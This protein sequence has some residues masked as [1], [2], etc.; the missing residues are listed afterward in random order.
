MDI[1]FCWNSYNWF[2]VCSIDT[3]R[4]CG[5]CGLPFMCHGMTQLSVIQEHV[6]R[7][8]T[9][10]WFVLGPWYLLALTGCRDVIGLCPTYWCQRNH[11]TKLEYQC[12]MALF[13]DQVI[14]YTDDKD[15]THFDFVEVIWDCTT[16]KCKLSQK[17]G[18]C[19]ALCHTLAENSAK[20]SSVQ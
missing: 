4:F 17:Q 10:L 3:Y 20:N 8:E 1:V 9:W 2:Y 6:S 15:Y 5:H 11:S 14:D 13:G 18:L 19:F 7:G 12:C 16:L